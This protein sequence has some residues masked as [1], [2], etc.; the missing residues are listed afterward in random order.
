MEIAISSPVDGLCL[1]ICVQQGDIVQAQDEL[2][3]I[4]E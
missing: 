3:V 1:E 2:I 4:S